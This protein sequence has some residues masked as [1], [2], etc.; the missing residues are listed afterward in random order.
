MRKLSFYVVICLVAVL[1][2]G[3]SKAEK[4]ASKSQIELAV[5]KAASAEVSSM[6]MG[7]RTLQMAYKVENNMYMECWPSPPGGG[8]DDIPDV[9]V[10]A[11]GFGDIGFRPEG[12]VRH[13]YAVIVSP[14]GKSYEITATGDLDKNGVK[15]VYTVTS[16]SP[17]QKREPANEY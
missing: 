11:G 13:Q 3:C 14:D 1:L 4:K 17:R 7:I 15:V 6:L 2:A 16:S 10:D 8:T 5:L 12:R 9:W